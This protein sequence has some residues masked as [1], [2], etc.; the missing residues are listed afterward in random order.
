MYVKEE[1]S[2]GEFVASVLKFVKSVCIFLKMLKVGI[3]TALQQLSSPEVNLSDCVLNRYFSS[4]LI[5][6]EDKLH[7]STTLL[8]FLKKLF[9]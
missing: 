8:V 2:Y 4:C 3:C 1:R 9:S 5:L 6:S 7:L